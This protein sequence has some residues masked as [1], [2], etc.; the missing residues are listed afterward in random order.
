ML[1]AE[2]TTPPA[3][4]CPLTLDLMRSPVSLKTPARVSY[5]R[6]ALD[7]WLYLHP[8]RDPLTNQNFAGPLE[9]EADDELRV[10]IDEWRRARNIEVEEGSRFPEYRRPRAVKKWIDQLTR[11]VDPALVEEAAQELATL[12]ESSDADRVAARKHGAIEALFEVVRGGQ[13][14]SEALRAACVRAIAQLARNGDNRYRI[15]NS[16]GI[17][18]LVKMI[19]SPSEPLCQE[20]AALALWRM[21]RTYKHW[22]AMAVE[23]LVKLLETRTY[24]PARANAVK[25]IWRLS[26]TEQHRVAIVKAGGLPKLVSLLDTNAHQQHYISQIASWTL[27]NLA[28]SA[29]YKSRV[30]RAIGFHFVVIQ[31]SLV[32]I[33]RHL[34]RKVH[35]EDRQIHRFSSRRRHRARSLSPGP[36]NSD[37]S[38]APAVATSPFV[39]R[40]SLSL[41]SRGS[42]RPRV[43]GRSAGP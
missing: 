14:S 2:E 8:R 5:E 15:A 19:L 10:Q 31:P 3:Y 6:E 36:R 40:H 38:E 11:R 28:C 17:P 39:R 33:K 26:V 35:P 30:C 29:T 13:A 41:R 16:G 43:R 7:Y 34:D 27:F 42:R 25:A 9:F 12:C 1:L 4:R 20:A 37:I 21:A 32:Q 18:P 24:P 23:P 22:I